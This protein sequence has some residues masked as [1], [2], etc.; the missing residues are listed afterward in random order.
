MPKSLIPNVFSTTLEVYKEIAIVR[1]ILKYRRMVFLAMRL[2]CSI[3][4]IYG[5][6]PKLA[7][8]G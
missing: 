4:D 1:N 8:N 3:F 5:E 6:N 2:F 7:Y